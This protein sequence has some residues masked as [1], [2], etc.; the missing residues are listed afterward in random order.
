MPCQIWS[1]SLLLL[2]V[3]PES[4]G[5]DLVFWTASFNVLTARAELP[6]AGTGGAVAEM[7]EWKPSASLSMLK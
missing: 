2:H 7:D 4:A 5:E 6:S 1:L 3:L